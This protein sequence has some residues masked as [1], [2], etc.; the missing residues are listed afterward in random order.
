M[1]RGTQYFSQFGCTDHFPPHLHHNLFNRLH[2]DGQPP[3]S[4]PR[5]RLC[6]YSH[7]MTFPSRTRP[8][9]LTLTAICYV[10]IR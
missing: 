1:F 6:P 9:A 5:G 2:S 10:S 8:Y 4:C 7:G 3:S